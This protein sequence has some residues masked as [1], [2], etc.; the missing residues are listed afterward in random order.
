MSEDDSESDTE[1][2]LPAVDDE[3]ATEIGVLLMG[4]ESERVLAG[5]GVAAQDGDPAATT[6]VVDQ[7]RHGVRPDLTFA[8]AL[9]TGAVR[10]Q[11]ARS[12]LS[13]AA[14][15]AGVRSAALRR[16][17]SAAVDVVAAAD[18]AVGAAQRVYFAACWLRRAQID[19]LCTRAAVTDP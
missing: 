17:W 11:A 9:A 19:Q 8:A 10:W 16:Q 5:L 7:L 6:L 3:P 14:P 2:S 18:V 4:L 15:V 13:D 12:R 1:F